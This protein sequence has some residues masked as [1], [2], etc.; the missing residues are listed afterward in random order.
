MDTLFVKFA[1]QIHKMLNASAEPIQFP[2][3]KRV[4]LTQRFLC[5]GES[6]PLGSAATKFVL[7]DFF[8]A[9][10]DQGFYLQFEFLILGGDACVEPINIEMESPQ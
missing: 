10:L 7:K 3:D 1:D 2:N 9:S 5:F 8:A 4:A 6:R